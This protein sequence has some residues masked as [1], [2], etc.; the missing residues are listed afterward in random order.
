MIRPVQSPTFGLS[1]QPFESMAETLRPGRVLS[2]FDFD[3]FTHGGN[4]TAKQVGV[5][6]AGMIFSRIA[7]GA[8]RSYNEAREH[9]LRDGLGYFFYL[10]TIPILSRL[11]IGLATPARY[12]E[13]LRH[14]KPM[15]QGTGRM[16]SLRRLSWRINPAAR[17]ST[18]T[19][20][21]LTDR[22]RQIKNTGLHTPEAEDLVRRIEGAM[23]YRQLNMLA[24]MVATVATLGIMVNLVNMAL[25][26]NNVAQGKIG[27]NR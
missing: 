16:A 14:E 5:V 12:R 27:H 18:T 9:I 13:L 7:A 20:E 4:I 11:F 26:R 25:T 17:Y 22:L 8:I 15:P 21:Q 2:R 23:K 3:A 10:F 6:Y 19:K 1:S 24:G